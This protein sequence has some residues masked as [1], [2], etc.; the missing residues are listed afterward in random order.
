MGWGLVQ[1]VT[2]TGDTKKPGEPRMRPGLW[3]LR[4]AG[5]LLIVT[6][7]LSAAGGAA[8]IVEI[9]GVGDREG[10]ARLW[11]LVRDEDGNSVK[12]VTVTVGDEGAKTN[13]RGRYE[14]DAVPAGLQ[15]VTFSKPGYVTYTV[16]RILVGVDFMTGWNRVDGPMYF[17][18]DVDWQGVPRVNVTFDIGPVTPEGE[19]DLDWDFLRF[20]LLGVWMDRTW[21]FDDG[22]GSD[23]GT[24]TPAK[25]E[26]KNLTG[27]RFSYNAT[28]YDE[29]L[30]DGQ[31][32]REPLGWTAGEVF[33]DSVNGTD[34]GR[35]V[36]VNVTGGQNVTG[37]PLERPHSVNGTL[38]VPEGFDVEDLLVTVEWADEAV[39]TTRPDADGSFEIGDLPPGRYVV[40]AWGKGLSQTEVR[41]VWLDNVT[42]GDLG[43]HTLTKG[44]EGYEVPFDSEVYVTCIGIYL[45]LTL[46]V[47]IAGVQTLRRGSYT[48]TVLGA[49]VGMF[50]GLL[51]ALGTAICMTSPMALIALV[52]IV[53][54]KSLYS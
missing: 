4:V 9:Q 34:E 8:L 32:K 37:A 21:N 27:G 12:D 7:F 44:E 20:T 23:T 36:V 31:T 22:T 10:E 1:G 48:F 5:V 53:R 3:T 40:K 16:N 46:L 49:T 26:L 54:G 15:S 38:A 11:G 2:G 19:A 45:L 24:R 13:S 28:T 18:R 43:S 50:L 25:V 52:L 33:I 35:V 14:F 42:D 41:Y 6:G 29:Y 17:D 30:E 51:G 47:I 39:N